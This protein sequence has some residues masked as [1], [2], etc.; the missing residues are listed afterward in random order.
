[1]GRKTEREGGRE[2]KMGVGPRREMGCFE[3]DGRNI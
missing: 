1:M 2:R 3:I